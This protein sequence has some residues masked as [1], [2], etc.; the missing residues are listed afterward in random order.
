MYDERIQALAARLDEA[1][2]PDPEL[3]R[4]ICEAYVLA[5]ADLADGGKRLVR[6][7]MLASRAM[8]DGNASDTLRAAADPDLP[9]VLVEALETIDRSVSNVYIAEYGN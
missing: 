8:A 6:L 2:A 5:L 9:R 3:E 4:D 1:T 7:G